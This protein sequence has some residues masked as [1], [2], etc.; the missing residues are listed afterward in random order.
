MRFAVGERLVYDIGNEPRPHIPGVHGPTFMSL[1]MNG[2]V[3]N[4]TEMYAA[5]LYVLMQR[6]FR[7]R[8]TPACAICYVQLPFRVDRRDERAANWE[9]VIPPP[10]A[11]SCAAVIDE[12][13][14]EFQQLYELKPDD[15][16]RA[17]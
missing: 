1:L 7:R 8:Q 5:D 15:R 4:R 17:S 12:I 6:E 3:K 16:Q 10:C 11:L 13:V 2:K 9:V 14:S